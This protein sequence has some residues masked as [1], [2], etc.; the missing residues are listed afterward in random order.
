MNDKFE[1]LRSAP[2][3][4]DSQRDLILD[5]TEI[6]PLGRSAALAHLIVVFSVDAENQ[7]VNSMRV[8]KNAR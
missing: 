8:N 3:S 4:I 1:Q 2:L 5:D 6:A 7:K